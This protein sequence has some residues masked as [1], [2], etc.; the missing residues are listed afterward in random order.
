MPKPFK[1]N[2]V[3]KLPPDAEIVDVDGRPHARIRERGRTATYP[4]SK[5]GR[6]YLRP[7]K[8][9][10]FEY[11]DETNTV[12]RKKGATDLKA[13]EQEAAR[14]E[15]RVARLKAGLIDPAEE[16][17]TRPLA[18]HLADYAA[19][20]EAKGGTPGHVRK[21]VSL[22]TAMLT[23]AEFVFPPDMDAARAAAWLNTLRRDDRPVELPAGEESFT[24][25]AA[26]TLLGV[27]RDA[28]AKAL[29]RRGLAGT[30]RGKARRIR[31]E[32]V[33]VLALAAARGVGPE[34]V[35][36]YVRAAKGFARWLTRTRRIP[37]NPLE[38]L[39]LLNAAV[40]VRRARRELTADEL[41]RLFEGTRTSGRA[42]RGLSGMDRF[43]LYLTAAG[44]GFRA[45]ALASLTPADLDLAADAPTVTLA[46]RAN[47]SRKTKVQPLPADVAVALR[48]RIARMPRHAS[49]WP[50]TW[51]TK[52]A[53][54]LRED[55]DA[56]GIPY[57]VEGPDGPEYA[58][59]HALRHTYLT[60]LGRHGVDLRTA[61]ELAG[62]STPILTARYT[63]R[64]LYDLA[65]AVEK[66]PPLVPEAGPGPDVGAVP[67]RLTGTDGG[68]QPDMTVRLSAV[69]GAVDGGISPHSTASHG[70]LRMVGGDGAEPAEGAKNK[71]A[72]ARLHRP[73]SSGTE[74]AD[75]GLNRGPS[76][77]QSLALP[78]ELSARSPVSSGT[79]TPRQRPAKYSTPATSGSAYS[80]RS[81]PANAAGSAA[82]SR[83]ARASCNRRNPSWNSPSVSPGWLRLTASNNSGN[84]QP[85]ADCSL[86][87]S[88]YATAA[89]PHGTASARPAER[90]G[91]VA[92]SRISASASR[93][94]NRSS[95]ACSRS[96]SAVS[97]SPKARRSA[98]KSSSRPGTPAR[99]SRSAERTSSSTAR[100]ES[101]A[102]KNSTPRGV[103]RT[104]SICVRP[105]TS[106]RDGSSRPSRNAEAAA[107]PAVPCRDGNRPAS[108]PD[109]YSRCSPGSSRACRNA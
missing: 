78:A 60:M 32:V 2:R 24:P 50:G 6:S 63:H 28:V 79:I 73:A 99:V 82:S 72:G 108:L 52:A 87:R 16:H 5:G 19:A 98:R 92:S 55:L 70:T 101:C 106:V 66:L 44:T 23:G 46:A 47:K 61:Q 81:S 104:H 31:R 91:P 68:A 30:G 22:V 17:A 12:R 53:E 3:C 1:P 89:L 14:M 96:A 67:L 10:Y 75:P 57:A 41:R 97:R 100:G 34:Q 8:C 77:F 69:P 80:G 26:A 88:R 90:P 65:G 21:T 85:P 7:A 95:R 18:G 36:H 9:W 83:N 86:R 103:T 11:R 48:D 35:N 58:D 37:A 62:H 64:R 33:E 27:T 54:M 15:R 13:T 43:T 25:A 51:P 84:G 76:D 20:L 59:F 56:V 40:D 29:K 107:S 39:A 102:A 45:S 4:L 94:S 38:T 42:F 74:W 49:L 93:A 71:P 105:F 109:R